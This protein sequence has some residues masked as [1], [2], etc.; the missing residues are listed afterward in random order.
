MIKFSERQLK[1]PKY[2]RPVYLVTAGQSKYD[3]AIPEK[4]TEELCID[5]FTMAAELHRHDS[6]RAEAATS[7]PATT[8]IS[9]TTSA[10]SSSARP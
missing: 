2:M 3:R 4:R 10:T 9:P 1:T 8:A 5:A 6:G 7:T